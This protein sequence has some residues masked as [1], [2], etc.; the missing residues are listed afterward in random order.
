MPFAHCVN[1][2]LSVKENELINH[3]TTRYE[4]EKISS[5]K[6]KCFWSYFFSEYVNLLN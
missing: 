2:D 6:S 3:K 5:V 4:A 1:D